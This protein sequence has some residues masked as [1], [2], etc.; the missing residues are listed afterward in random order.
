MFTYTT[1]NERVNNNSV[2]YIVVQVP[3]VS[4]DG[5]YP[6]KLFLQKF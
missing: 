1:Y 5:R 6:Y 4:K 3:I 2:S